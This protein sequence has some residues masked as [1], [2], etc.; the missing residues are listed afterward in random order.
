MFTTTRTK[1]QEKKRRAYYRKIT[2]GY[3]VKLPRQIKLFIQYDPH[4]GHYTDGGILTIRESGNPENHGTETELQLGYN[5]TAENHI[6]K[7][8]EYDFTRAKAVREAAAYIS[9]TPQAYTRD[10]CYFSSEARSIIPGIIE[11]YFLYKFN[12]ENVE[13]L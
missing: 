8:S 9:G 7:N 4:A 6:M 1:E 5:W 12:V 10:H 3:T 11:E 13:E 2:K